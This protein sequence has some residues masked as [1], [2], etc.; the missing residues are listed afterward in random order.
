MPFINDTSSNETVRAASSD[1][2][3]PMIQLRGKLSESGAH[4]TVGFEDLAGEIRNR[5]YLLAIEPRDI[6]IQWL[7]KQK[8]L[9]HSVYR[10]ER[11][12]LDQVEPWGS[13][14]DVRILR[15][16]YGPRA[17][18]ILKQSRAKLNAA[19]DPKQ[20]VPKLLRFRHRLAAL[21]FTSKM[22]SMEALTLFYSIHSFGFTSRSLLEKFLATIAPAAKA[23]IYRIYIQHGTYGDPYQWDNIAW[24]TIHDGKW[25]RLCERISEEMT[26][27][28]DLR[29]HLRINDHPIRLDLSAEWTASLLVFSG[30]NLKNF[31][32]ELVS[33]KYNSRDETPL[34]LCANVVRKA[35]LLTDEDE[36]EQVV[37]KIVFKEPVIPKAKKILRLKM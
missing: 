1:H 22:I 33:R 30:K 23:S 5:I 12:Y 21:L 37:K 2:A 16:A 11:K 8:S 31:H 10:F 28:E 18:A 3:H 25:E 6:E 9:T 4:K 35:V 13:S 17:K 24:K 14:K 19:K 32:V 20:P 26:G 7:V 27:L 36:P 29:V 34:K 15:P